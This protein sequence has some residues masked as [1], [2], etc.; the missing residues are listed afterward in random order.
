MRNEVFAFCEIRFNSVM[1]KK[2]LF[3]A[4]C[5]QV[6]RDEAFAFC[7]IRFNSVVVK[8]RYLLP[9]AAEQCEMKCSPFAKFVST[10]SS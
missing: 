3:A 2:T 9:F 8:K 5:S 10:V 7:E 1:V 4:L 6:M